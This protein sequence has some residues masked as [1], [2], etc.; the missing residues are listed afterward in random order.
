MKCLLFILFILTSLSLQA[1]YKLAFTNNDSSK[2]ITIK[3]KDLTRLSYNG[4]MNQPQEAEGKVSSVTDSSI[5]LSP[6]KKF[7]Q[8]KQAVQTIL[9][10]NITGFRQYSKSRPAAEIIYGVAGVGVTGA[11]AGIVS[12]GKSA[13]TVLTILSSAATAAVT[14]GLKNAIFSH[15][16]K[17][18]LANGWIMHLV[19]D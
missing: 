12:N 8:K 15:R 9:I 1:Q 5:T 4:Y 2:T 10:R 3:Q 19:Q 16:I 11:V 14:T 18:Y 6:R 7:L 13:S 17:N